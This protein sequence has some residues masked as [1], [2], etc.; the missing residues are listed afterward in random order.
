MKKLNSLVLIAL[1]CVGTFISSCKKDDDEPAKTENAYKGSWEGTFTGDDAG[2]WTAT[3]SGSGAITGSVKS[4]NLPGTSF[5]VSGSVSSAGKFEAVT[6][7][8][9]DSVVFTGDG[10]GGSVAAGLW[11]NA[12]AGLVGI[13]SGEKK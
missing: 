8:M 1:L 10:S 3:I 6:I 7:I 2:T 13:W 4:N 9:G 5:P 12:N 11:E